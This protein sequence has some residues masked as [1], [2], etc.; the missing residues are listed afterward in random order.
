[1]WMQLVGFIANPSEQIRML[2]IEHLVPYSL[3][4]PAIFKT[5]QLLP[6]KHLKILIRD[7][8]VWQ[9]PSSIDYHGRQAD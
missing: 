3:D 8:T 7:H 9:S 4:Q 2:A 6:I 5:D 1:M